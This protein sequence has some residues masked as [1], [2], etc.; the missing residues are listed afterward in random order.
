MFYIVGPS[1]AKRNESPVST[2]VTTTTSAT[3]TLSQPKVVTPSQAGMVVTQLTPGNLTLRPQAKVVT[4]GLPP[5]FLVPPG[6]NSQTSVTQQ[7]KS[8]VC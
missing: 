5:Q 2:I 3:T 1:D 6:V 8:F 7:G 4:A